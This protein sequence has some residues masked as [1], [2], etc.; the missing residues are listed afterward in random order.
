MHTTNDVREQIRC[1]LRTLGFA[2]HHAGYRLLADAILLY[3]ENRDLSVTKELYPALAK[4]SG[5]YSAASIERSIRYAIS[6]AWNHG[7]HEHWYMLFPNQLKA[8]SNMV[9][10]A[11][12][13][14][15]WT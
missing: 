6:E 8:P 5:L 14:E 2:P 10:I 9:F 1:T 7:P 15:S 3:I 11:V 13:A 12:L 4:Q